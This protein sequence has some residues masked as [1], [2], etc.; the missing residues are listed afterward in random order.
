MKYLNPV[1]TGIFASV[2]ASYLTFKVYSSSAKRTDYSMARLFLRR[3]DAIKSL[4]MLIG[5]LIIFA[6]GRAV[7]M[8]I[9]LNILEESA[10]YYIRVPIDVTATILLTYSLVILY[11]VIKP[12]ESL[13][14]RLHVSLASHLSPL[15]QSP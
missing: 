9:L 4:K 14:S 7:S 5:S 3:E 11:K 13:T 1:L 10:I 6:S 12:K 2:I 15:V 8:L